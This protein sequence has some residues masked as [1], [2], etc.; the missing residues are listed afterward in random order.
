MTYENFTLTCHF[1][2]GASS[3]IIYTRNRAN[4]NFISQTF[5]TSPLKAVTTGLTGA[6]NSTGLQAAPE[7]AP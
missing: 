4:F 2:S 5:L 7:L 1:Y 6:N 3:L